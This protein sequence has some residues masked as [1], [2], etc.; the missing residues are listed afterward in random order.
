MVLLSDAFDTPGDTMHV[1]GGAVRGEWVVSAERHGIRRELRLPFS[2][3][4]LWS[5]LTP[6]GVYLNPATT[7]LSAL[8]LGGLLFPT[9]YWLRRA[10]FRPQVLVTIVLGAVLALLSTYSLARLESPQPH[11]WAGT[12]IGPFVGWLAAGITDRR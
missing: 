8:W 1:S 5:G 9:G 7:W 6:F 10:G 2:A 3:G 4:L 12:L 11:E